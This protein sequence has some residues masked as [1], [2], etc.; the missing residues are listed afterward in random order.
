MYM[1]TIAFHFLP[2]STYHTHLQIHFLQFIYRF[3]FPLQTNFV[4]KVSVV[5]IKATQFPAMEICKTD[6]Y[7]NIEGLYSLTNHAIC[8]H[9]NHVSLHCSEV[10]T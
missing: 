8:R 7:I 10:K 9:E 2:D 1:L 4:T 6:Q 3:R 5:F